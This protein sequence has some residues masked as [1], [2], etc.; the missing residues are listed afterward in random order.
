MRLASVKPGDLVLV[1]LRGDRFHAMVS[2]PG[3][4]KGELEVK[5]LNVKNGY[6][7]FVTARHVIDHWRHTRTTRARTHPG[8]SPAPLT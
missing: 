4:R 2:G 8:F 3:E 5:P 6:I 1:D 7:R